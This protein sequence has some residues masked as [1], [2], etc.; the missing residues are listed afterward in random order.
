MLLWGYLA[1]TRTP[2]LLT[3]R[4]LCPDLGIPTCLAVVSATTG[5]LG[6]ILVWMVVPSVAEKQFMQ[7]VVSPGESGPLYWAPQARRT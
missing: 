3:A 7:L 4:H 6:T 1:L 5:P 2:T